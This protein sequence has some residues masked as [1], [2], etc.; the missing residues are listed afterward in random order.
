MLREFAL[1][2]YVCRDRKQ[3]NGHPSH[4]YLLSALGCAVEAVI[5]GRFLALERPFIGS[6]ARHFARFSIYTSI[7]L[8]RMH[9]IGAAPSEETQQPEQDHREGGCRGG[10]ASGVVLAQ[11]R[12]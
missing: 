7:T 5:D 12:Y 10:V 11:D 6:C 1:D 8:K 4:S 9:C 3:W 2:Q